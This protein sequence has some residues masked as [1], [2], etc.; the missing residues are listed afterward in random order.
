M[1][2][3]LNLHKPKTRLIILFLLNKELSTRKTF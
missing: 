3:L 2:R 1:L